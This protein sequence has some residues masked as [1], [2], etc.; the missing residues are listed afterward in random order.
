MSV[1][2]NFGIRSVKRFG[3]SKG[4]ESELIDF[5]TVC[6][7]LPG[8]HVRIVRMTF[9]LNDLNARNVRS[10]SFQSEPLERLCGI[11][12]HGP[13]LDGIQRNSLKVAG[14]VFN[15]LSIVMPYGDALRKIKHTV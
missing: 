11:A 13:Y 14:K 1:I 9:V 2:R 8:R 7:Q 3:Q 4:A 12:V 10:L 15:P 5:L 6:F